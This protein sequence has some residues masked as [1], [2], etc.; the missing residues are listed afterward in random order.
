VPSSR[1]DPAQLALQRALVQG[2]NDREATEDRH[3]TQREAA[4]VHTI[5]ASPRSITDGTA[6]SQT[7]PALAKY[8][9]IDMGG[10]APRHGD[11]RTGL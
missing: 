1:L 5:R 7:E 9:Y 6:A 4:A 8:V 2:F 10:G 11:I 3:T